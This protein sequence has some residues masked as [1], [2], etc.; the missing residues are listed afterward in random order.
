MAAAT[1]NQVISTDFVSYKRCNPLMITMSTPVHKEITVNEKNSQEIK[2]KK[3]LVGYR[4]NYAP[5]D[6]PPIIDRL[7]I[8]A[9]WLNSEEGLKCTVNGSIVRWSIM[10]KFNLQ[11][12]KQAK[13]YDVFT[14][15][16]VRRAANLD[17]IKDQIGMPDFDGSS[18][19]NAEKTKFKNFVFRPKEKGKYIEGVSPT[20]FAEL[21]TTK[22]NK[23]LFTLPVKEG[24]EPEYVEWQSL[25]SA[26]IT[27]KPCF[28]FCHDQSFKNEIRTKIFLSSAV[29]GSVYPCG[30]RVRNIK[31]AHSAAKKGKFDVDEIRANIKL[32]TELNESSKVAVTEPELTVDA[33][34]P[35]SA[36]FAGLSDRNDRNDRNERVEVKEPNVPPFNPA[37]VNI[38]NFNSNYQSNQNYPQQSQNYQQQNQNYQQQQPSQNYQQQSQNYQQQN[39][40]SQSFSNPPPIPTPTPTTGSSGSFPLPNDISSF[41]SFN[42]TPTQNSDRPFDMR[43]F[44]NN[45]PPNSTSFR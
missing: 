26:N 22:K 4:Y 27:M 44:A 28:F 25:V 30:T 40:S 34:P 12:P 7:F 2:L 23:T 24:D 15:I 17:E 41:I 16:Y 5:R 8:N 42:P 43:S 3:S 1:P 9:T 20:F 33:A 19:A 35:D 14:E 37:S 11:D 6:F 38:P 18:Q 39:Q 36:T 31:S 32:I 10:F 45:L 13:L 21:N 29:I